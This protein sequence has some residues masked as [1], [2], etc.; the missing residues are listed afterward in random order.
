MSDLISNEINQLT[1]DIPKLR[2]YGQD[3]LFSALCLKYFLLDGYIG[4]RDFKS[5]FVDGKNDGGID[6]ITIDDSGEKPRL[7]FI[8]G[9]YITNLNNTQEIVDIFTKMDQTINDFKNN[10]Y[11]GYNER[12]K[13]IYIQNFELVKDQNPDLPQLILFIDVEIDEN[14]REWVKNRLASINDSYEITIIDHNQIEEQ[15]ELINNPLSSVTED[16]I[17]WSKDDGKLAYGDDGLLVNVYANSVRRLYLK[18]KDKGLFAQNFRYYIRNKKIDD[19]VNTTLQK[20]RN[21]FWFLNNGII[22]GC[23]DFQID[24]TNIKLF[25]FSIIN[26]CQTTSLIGDYS[27]SNEG[28][29]FKIHCK[30]VKSSQHGQNFVAEIAEASNSQK[31]ILDRDL[32]ANYPEQQKLKKALEG[33][34]PPVFLEVKRG[35]P[36]P[37]KKGKEDWQFIRNDVLGQLILSFLFQQPGTARSN[38]QKIFADIQTYNKIF[39][40]NPDTGM[41]VDLL[42]VT[43]YYKT[44][45]EKKLT[46]GTAI[47]ED[48]LNNSEKTVIA[49]IGFIVKVKRK[50]VDY[51]K[52]RNSDD[53]ETE[54]SKDDLTGSFLDESS[55]KFERTLEGLFTMLNKLIF[56]TFKKA[57]SDSKG[58]SNFLKLD[59]KYRDLILV[60]FI[61]SKYLNDYEF[62]IF[63]DN[64]LSILK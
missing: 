60:D 18:H 19:S 2:E 47:D 50:L 6:L 27:G 26:G 15:I 58:V 13:R 10:K 52:F 21:D 49:L 43:S 8:Q 14:K 34:V 63:N 54:L 35:Q 24:G 3:Y 56:D 1:L 64:Y 12:L 20:R 28:E 41:L 59:S 33:N 9:K 30:I 7:I 48:V 37:N 57:E 22:I 31:P 17:E 42:K 25:D 32:K 39:R 62:D 36:K 29:D 5:S 45:C 46:E 51:R 44:Y 61:Q 23:E 53:W 4:F 38:K 40:R 16:K 55:D 11:S